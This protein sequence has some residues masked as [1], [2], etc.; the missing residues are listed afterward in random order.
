MWI[1]EQVNCTRSTTTL[2]TS[3]TGHGAVLPDVQDNMDVKTLSAGAIEPF[4]ESGAS[5]IL[6][7]QQLRDGI[8]DGLY[9]QKL[10]MHRDIRQKA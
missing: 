4:D 7:T 8:R 6:H 1:S 5:A 2:F 10:D 3:L 9:M